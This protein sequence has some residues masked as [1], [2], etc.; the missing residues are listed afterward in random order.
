MLTL[1]RALL[2][3]GVVSQGGYAVEYINQS[4]KSW[5]GAYPC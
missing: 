2:S 3:A 4:L 1:P 5:K